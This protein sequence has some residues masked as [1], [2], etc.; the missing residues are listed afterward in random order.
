MAPIDTK[1]KG[2]RVALDGLVIFRRERLN[3]P[4]S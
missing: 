2:D 1:K 4:V 3:A